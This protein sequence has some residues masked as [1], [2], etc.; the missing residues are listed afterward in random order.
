MRTSISPSS[1]RFPSTSKILPEVCDPLFQ[2]IVVFLKV[3][4]SYFDFFF[5]LKRPPK[6]TN[7]VAPIRIILIHSPV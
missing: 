6:A 4:H 7:S 2:I 5:G 3:F 1:D